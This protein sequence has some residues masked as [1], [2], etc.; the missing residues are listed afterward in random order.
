MIVYFSASSRNIKEDI[1]TY[2]RIL[3][4]IRAAGHNVSNDWTESALIRSDFTDIVGIVNDAVRSIDSAEV[5]I[6]EASD[7]STFGV[8]YEVAH[9]LQRKKPVLLL[10]NKN[11]EK[12]SYATGLNDELITLRQYDDLT[13]EEVVTGF[14]ADNEVKTKDL[15][16][17]FVI[18]RRIYNHLRLKSFKSG[19]TK[20]EVV[21]DLLL[22]DLQEGEN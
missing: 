3:H 16:F 13:I 7:V 21:R 5:L 18:D 15:R 9:A 20:A 17:N 4:A 14:L 19:K 22:K 6:A 12:S 8:G 1:V 11:V 2:K 10:I